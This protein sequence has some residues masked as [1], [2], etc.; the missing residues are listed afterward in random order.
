MNMFAGVSLGRQPVGS[1][2]EEMSVGLGSNFRFIRFSCGEE[3]VEF[4][5]SHGVCVVYDDG[6]VCRSSEI[7]ESYEEVHGPGK[8]HFSARDAALDWVS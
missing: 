2:M 7:H 4:T 3:A 6:Q 5:G 1:S 8:D